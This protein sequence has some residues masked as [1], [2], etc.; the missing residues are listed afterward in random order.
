M[1]VRHTFHTHFTATRINQS[2][3]L[4]AFRFISSI[5]FMM[6]PHCRNYNKETAAY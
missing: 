4:F 3:V 5:Y 2:F 1:R 6:L